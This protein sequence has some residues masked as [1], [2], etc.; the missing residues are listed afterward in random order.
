MFMLGWHTMPDFEY[1]IQWLSIY[2]NWDGVINRC[3]NLEK[4]IEMSEKLEV[5]DRSIAEYNGNDYGTNYNNWEFGYEPLNKYKY[6]TM[7]TDFYQEIHRT[8]LRRYSCNDKIVCHVFAIKSIILKMIEQLF[9][10]KGELINVIDE[11]LVEFK[12]SKADGR[13]NK[14]VAYTKFKDW[15]DIQVVG[16]EVKTKELL[17]ES[18]LESKELNKVRNKNS[19]VGEWFKEHT[20]SKGKYLV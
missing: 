11:E 7:V 19:F 10:R 3:S 12:E 17:L 18:G 2:V 6:F 16:R 13:K 8:K 9:P 5:K 4:A 20:I 14:G 1:V 15:L